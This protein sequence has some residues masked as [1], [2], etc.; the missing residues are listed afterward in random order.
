ML[1]VTL[2]SGHQDQNGLGFLLS[3]IY[4]NNGGYIC[5]TISMYVITLLS[6]SLSL[7]ES[8]FWFYLFPSG[9]SRALLYAGL[10]PQRSLSGL[11]LRSANVTLTGWSRDRPWSDRAL[12][13]WTL[14]EQY[15]LWED[16]S[17][18][19]VTVDLHLLGTLSYVD[20]RALYS[21]IAQ[22]G[23]TGTWSGRLLK[24]DTYTLACNYLSRS[25]LFNPC[26][27]HIPFE[28]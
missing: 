10:E 7:S 11:P 6:T 15:R 22:A 26:D 27:L 21:V 9:L 23:V 8:C 24:Q 25:T 2:I 4:R 20:P 5:V 16:A 1:I 18:L 13:S 17:L 28:Q 14:A 3:S 12:V 19:L